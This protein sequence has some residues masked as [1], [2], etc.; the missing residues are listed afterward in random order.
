MRPSN[1]TPKSSNINNNNT[2]NFT[3]YTTTTAS[4]QPNLKKQK[5]NQSTA[6]NN[7]RSKSKNNE[8]QNQ[9][10]NTNT[11][12]SCLNQKQ[13]N[14]TLT[15]QLKSSNSVN[16][17]A[18]AK[19]G[20]KKNYMKETSSFL[21]KDYSTSIYENNLAV[22]CVKDEK[23]KGMH[24]A[25]KSISNNDKNTL[26]FISSSYLRNSPSS[27]EPFKKYSISPNQKNPLQSVI[28]E[29]SDFYEE[30][31]FDP[32]NYRLKYL[33]ELGNNFNENSTYGVNHNKITVRSSNTNVNVNTTSNNLISPNQ[34]KS[35][36]SESKLLSG[37]SSSNIGVSGSQLGGVN[38]NLKKSTVV[39]KNLNINN[40]NYDPNSN[41]LVSS[42][43]N[44]NNN[45]LRNSTMNGSGSN[46][47]QKNSIKNGNNKESKEQSKLNP[48]ANVNLKTNRSKN[49][50]TVRN[51]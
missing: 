32:I 20:V 39:K 48:N 15:N 42:V 1:L 36:K 27:H 18:E 17:F 51:L 5:E 43:K 30:D 16:N 47:Y 35:L 2:S 34:L 7:S 24:I 46:F 29:N 14:T 22:N 12:S 13:S 10:Q 9:N 41:H 28:D 50:N 3:N 4:N 37:S 31:N 44:I 40:N 11:N 25:H 6:L 33:N 23:Q 21:R 26:D 38:N 8:N 45:G 19:S 49:A